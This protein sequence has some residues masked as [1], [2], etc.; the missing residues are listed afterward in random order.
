LGLP[1]FH[2]FE[3]EIKDQVANDVY[4]REVLLSELALDSESIVSAVRRARSGES[5][6]L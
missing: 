4:R 1:V 6:P 2:I 5:I 3:H